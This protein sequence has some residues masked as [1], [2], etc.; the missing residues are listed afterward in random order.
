MTYFLT[1]RRRRLGVE[2]AKLL[3]R[4]SP[5]E[6]GSRLFIALLKIYEAILEI[7]KR[8]KIV[9]RERFSSELMLSNSASIRTAQTDWVTI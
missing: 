4:V 2:S 3:A 5:L 6:W 1:P 8:G 9:G 7:G